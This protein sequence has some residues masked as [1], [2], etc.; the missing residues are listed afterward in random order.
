MLFTLVMLEVYTDP[1]F[2]QI[3]LR[4]PNTVA[5]VVKCITEAK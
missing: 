2:D 1:S 3:C 4:T 5:F